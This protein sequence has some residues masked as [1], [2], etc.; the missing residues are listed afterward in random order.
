MSFTTKE[1]KTL[2]FKNFIFLTVFLAPL[3]S[4]LWVS[5]L[6]FTSLVTQAVPF[7]YLPSR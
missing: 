7:Q 3:M 5:R 2:E 4:I 6:G 1:E